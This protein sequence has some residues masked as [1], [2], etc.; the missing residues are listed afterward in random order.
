M[1]EILKIRC[2][3]ANA[4]A[5]MVCILLLKGDEIGQVRT[6]IFRQFTSYS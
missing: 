1:H 6:T 2:I 4:I 3:I 5:G